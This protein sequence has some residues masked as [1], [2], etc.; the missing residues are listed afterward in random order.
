MITLDTVYRRL[1]SNLLKGKDTERCVNGLRAD[2]G[3]Y[4]ED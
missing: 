1:L 4:H 2:D 3:F